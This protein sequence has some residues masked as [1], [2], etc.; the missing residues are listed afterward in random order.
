V[1]KQNDTVAE[2]CDKTVK[3]EEEWGDT[4]TS[5]TRSSTHSSSTH[6]AR[7]TAPQL[8]TLLPTLLVV[9]PSVLIVVLVNLPLG[10]YKVA[11]K[12]QQI[13]PDGA[14]RCWHGD[15]VSTSEYD[16]RLGR[17]GYDFLTATAAVT[18]T[19]RHNLEFLRSWR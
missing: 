14:L 13:M 15:D 3:K 11:R 6:A 18:R 1:T 16:T 8:H 9:Y 12:K 7:L 5:A 17:E 19:Q 2:A 4:D 10:L